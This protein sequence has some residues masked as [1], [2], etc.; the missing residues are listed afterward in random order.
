MFYQP[1]NMVFPQRD[2]GLRAFTLVELLALVVIITILVALILVGVK[3]FLEK[4]QGVACASNMRQVGVGLWSYRSDHGGYF[5]PGKPK[6]PR[7]DLN[8]NGTLVP[9][10]LSELPLCP[11]AKKTLTSAEQ[12]RYGSAKVWYQRNMGTYAINDVLTQWK[13]EA[14]PWP[15]PMWG[16]ANARQYSASRMP[17]LLETRYGTSSSW[18]MSHQN[19]VLEGSQLSGV[20][21]RSHG[22]GDSLNFM[23][24]DGHIE[25]ISR[26]D[27][28]GIAEEQKSWVYPINPNGRF[29]VT[30]SDGRFICPNQISVSKFEELFGER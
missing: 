12:S 16:G 3:V 25:L 13:V 30:G 1:P 11:S 22:K 24:L 23:F 27:P 4:A 19:D 2:I 15:V 20:P 14:M 6:H 26:N 7:T 5:P 10:Y 18:S 29:N 17:L 21:P 8:F 28:R 9:D